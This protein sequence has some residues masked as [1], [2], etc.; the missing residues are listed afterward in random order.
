MKNEPAF[1]MSRT[2]LSGN[3]GST[4]TLNMG[5][6]TKLEYFAG[7]AMQGV[8]SNQKLI[9]HISTS[10]YNNKKHKIDHIMGFC[11]EHAKELIKQ[12]ES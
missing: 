5:G 10:A 2:T 4:E 3:L 9:E 11:V 7:Q 12:L 6:L 8:L 1:P